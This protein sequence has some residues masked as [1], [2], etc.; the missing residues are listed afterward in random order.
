MYVCPSCVC[1][2]IKLLVETFLNATLSR[3]EI[4][5]L[6]YWKNNMTKIGNNYKRQL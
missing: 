3:Q 4:Q 6:A 2:I 1:R 5:P